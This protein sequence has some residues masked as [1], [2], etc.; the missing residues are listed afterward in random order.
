M[1]LNK[2]QKKYL[3]FSLIFVGIFIGTFLVLYMLGLVPEELLTNGNSPADSI[4]LGLFQSGT[5]GQDKNEG[6]KDIPLKIQIPNV[7]VDVSI[8]DPN[9]TDNAVL[10]EFL[11]KGA[12]RYPGSGYAGSGNLFLFGHSSLLSVVHNQAYKAFNKIQDLKPGDEIDVYSATAK[13]IYSVRDE[14][15]VKASEEEVDIAS[16]ENML[17]LSTCDLL[18]ATNEARYVVRADYVSKVS[19]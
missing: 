1:T 16:K 18:G 7:G 11:L 6:P 17:T 15:L 4:K 3:T 10:N 2:K 19:L 14:R 8:S 12:V 5:N 9:T 13:Y